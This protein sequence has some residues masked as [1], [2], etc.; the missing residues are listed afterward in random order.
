MYAKPLS[1]FV[2]LMCYLS[3]FCHGKPNQEMVADS[4]SL[5]GVTV[6]GET[7]L[8]IVKINLPDFS[9]DIILPNATE[10][11]LILRA[12]ASTLNMP[13]FAYVN[14]PSPFKSLTQ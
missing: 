5:I 7:V 9:V 2:L 13:N 6:T 10:V 14:I 1:T 3:Q 12:L 8:D 4:G 11:I